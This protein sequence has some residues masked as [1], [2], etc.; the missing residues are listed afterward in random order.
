MPRHRRP[1]VA[2]VIRRFVR[3]GRAKLLLALVIAAVVAAIWGKRS[4]VSTL[5]S[6]SDWVTERVSDLGRTSF[7][8][9]VIA[10]ILASMVSEDLT[11]IGCG[12]LAAKGVLPI[13]TAL[14]G[15]FLGLWLG[16]VL[17]YCAGRLVG[18]N[19]LKIAPFKWL[20][21]EAALARGTAWL[22]ERG[23][24]VVFIGR[25]VPGSRAPTYFASGV[26]RG[27]ALPF[28]CYF[29]LAS[30]VWVPLLVGGTYLMGDAL[31]ERFV[32]FAGGTLGGLILLGVSILLVVKLIEPLC[33]QR[34]RRMMVG[35]WRRK[36]QWEFWPGWL[37]NLPV[38]LHA[39]WLGH[40]CGDFSLFTSANP[41]IWLGGL[42]GESK[43]QILQSLDAPEENELAYTFIGPRG[44]PARRL[45]RVKAF[46][47]A[48]NLDYP[49]VLKPDVGERGSGVHVVRSDEQSRQ[50]LA[51]CLEAMIV[52]EYA[53]GEEFGVFY[54]RYPNEPK[55]RINSIVHKIIPELIGDGERSLDELILAD[56]R[57]VCMAATYL[58]INADRLSWV[59]AAGERVPLTEIGNHAQ[60]AVFAD[61]RHL[62]TPEMVDTFDRIAKRFKGG[63]YFGRFD[64]RAPSAEHLQRGEGIKIIEL[65]GVSSGSSH[66]YD[67]AVPTREVYRTLFRQWRILFE[68]SRQNVA[69]G[70]RSADNRETMRALWEHCI[71]KPMGLMPVHMEIR[72]KRQERLRAAQF[73][74]A[75]G[76]QAG[77]RVYDPH[78]QM[79]GVHAR[80]DADRDRYLSDLGDASTSGGEQRQTSR[81]Y[82]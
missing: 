1:I 32:H 37:A 26:L 17:L 15:C 69:A 20:I 42:F 14:V 19:L 35:F 53:T 16:D 45:V 70:I 49:V 23:A 75:P 7:V 80:R 28:A 62:H 13:G 81:R 54:Y 57:A 73:G 66:V 65:N 47:K 40:K 82:R 22:E 50:V 43:H 46:M 55:G 74:Q 52:Q 38:I 68:I 78:S 56:P 25:F 63:F 12:L 33:S 18:R 10:I 79:V 71:V 21:S 76:A 27:K 36:F 24:I 48:Y 30:L 77:G 61:A 41:G 44:S 60:G 6:A 3:S 5:A 72:R 58:R 59:P 39:L 31:A 11:C 51:N 8:L 34:G 4:D 67:P 64:V 2:D 29:A 9:T